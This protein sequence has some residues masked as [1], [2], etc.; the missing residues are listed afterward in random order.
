MGFENSL[1]FFLRF[2]FWKFLVDREVVGLTTLI[3]RFWKENVDLVKLLIW[4]GKKRL[5]FQLFWSD[6]TETQSGFFFAI[7][8]RSCFGAN[9]EAEVFWVLGFGIW[10]IQFFW[11]RSQLDWLSKESKAFKGISFWC[12]HFF[13]LFFSLYLILKRIRTAVTDLVS[14]E[15]LAEKG[16]K[17]KKAD[18]WTKKWNV[19]TLTTALCFW[20]PEN[21]MANLHIDSN[22]I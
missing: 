4:S 13:F 9:W 1:R 16:K 22:R 19:F 17:K 2:L 3:T 12:V 21:F 20:Q 11:V 18:N 14:N 7:G 10:V 5:W 8:E 6:R 15:F